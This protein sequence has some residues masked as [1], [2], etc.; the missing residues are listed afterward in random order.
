MT[1]LDRFQKQPN[2]VKRY[3]VDYSDWL[4]TGEIITSVSTSVSLINSAAGD[5]GE[6]TLTI[7][8]TE[9][10]NGNQFEYYVSSGTNGKSYKVTFLADTSDSQTEESEIEFKVTD[11]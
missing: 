11:T 8:S 7:G 2:E 5:V 1:L 3:T 10:I 6:P 4:A 9:I